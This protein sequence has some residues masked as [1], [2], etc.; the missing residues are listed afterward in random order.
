MRA[1]LI[2]SLL[3]A[4]AGCQ[5]VRAGLGEYQKTADRGV[6]LKG[7]QVG[8][9]AIGGTDSPSP[10]PAG[11]VIENAT[12]GDTPRAS[13]KKDAPLLPAGLGGDKANRA[14]SAEAPK[15]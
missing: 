9:V 15:P 5:T 8:P 13:G 1:G 10:A 11:T 6:G 7:S 14:Y 2:V 3:L 4:L 12:A